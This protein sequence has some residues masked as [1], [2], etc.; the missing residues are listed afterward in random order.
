MNP[1]SASIRRR[2]LNFG[3]ASALTLMESRALH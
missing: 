2:A 1:L 3:L